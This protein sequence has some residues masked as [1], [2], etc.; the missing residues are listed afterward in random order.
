MKILLNLIFPTSGE[1]ALFGCAPGDPE[2]QARIGY[3]P[4]APYFYEYLNGPRIIG[5]LRQIV[6]CAVRAN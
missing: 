1:V 3:L 2:A 4:E 6:Q 5:V